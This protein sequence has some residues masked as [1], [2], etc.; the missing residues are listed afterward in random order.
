[1]KAIFPV[2]ISVIIPTY[3]R[4]ET[5]AKSIESV[6]Q[7]TK[8]NFELIIVDDGSDDATD[9]FVGTYKDSRIT[10]FKTDH[11][12]ANHARN[13]GMRKARGEY[14]A[15][16]D[17]DVV[18]EKTFLEKRI[19]VLKDA[20][21]GADI[22]FGRVRYVC[23]EEESYI[24][25]KELSQLMLDD[26]KKDLW[27]KEILKGNYIDTSSALC[28]REIVMAV[29]GFDEAFKRNQDWDFFLRLFLREESK[30]TYSADCL[31]TN[32]IQKDSI[33]NNDNLYWDNLLRFLKKH[34]AVYLQY[35]RWIDISVSRFLNGYI[36]ACKEDYKSFLNIFEEYERE[37]FNSEIMKRTAMHF[38]SKEG[39]SYT[40]N[41]L[42]A[43][44]KKAK[45][46]FLYG[47]GEQANIC[48][49][50]LALFGIEYEGFV[51]SDSTQKSDNDTLCIGQIQGSKSDCFF[52]VTVSDWKAQ[53]VIS[54]CLLEQGFENYMFWNGKGHH[55]IFC[56]QD[57]GG[58]YKGGF[59][60]KSGVLRNYKIIG[61][62]IRKNCI[63]PN[64]GSRDRTRWV[65][66]VLRDYTDILTEKCDVLHFAPDYQLAKIINENLKCNY[67]SADIKDGK[68]DIT[69]DITDIP[70]NTESIDYI[71]ANHVLEHVENEYK[72]IKE[73]KRV[74]RTNGKIVLSFPICM[75]IK[76]IDGDSN[77]SGA[78]RIE[79]FG[80]I[81]H[82][83]LYG[84][85]FLERIKS[86]GLNVKIYTPKDY[87]DEDRA[88]YFGFIKD[89]VVM[90]CTK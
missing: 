34:K 12:G 60:S 52:I 84:N 25:D 11:I 32:Y 18:W 61:A 44:V 43:D 7:Q 1:M 77:L 70:L 88:D 5:I 15:F 85:D 86:Y 4:K 79:R 82:I 72:A 89:D 38:A 21:G 46:L 42:L 69:A 23:G 9:E 51:V 58:F 73:L 71:I 30:V 54:R 87:M 3:N 33:S 27:I 62:G 90:I 48:E 40:W 59:N 24:P 80:Q 63:C 36:S 10:F 37:G 49:R 41:N 29:N 68:A 53:K 64:C 81:D 17:S 65:Y 47:K 83:R 26:Y 74:I 55:C 35:G 67:I 13:Y 19:E 2:Q 66:K 76:T 45:R 14:I 57:M 78:E 6:L 16:L 28:K 39:K 20:R 56:E 31:V 22:A 75:D 8:Q 50:T